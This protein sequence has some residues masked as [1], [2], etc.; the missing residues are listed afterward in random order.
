MGK[1]PVRKMTKTSMIAGLEGSI[2]IS[3]QTVDAKSKKM[4]GVHICNVECATIAGAGCVEWIIETYSIN[5]NLVAAGFA[6]WWTIFV[7]KR[8][9][10]ENAIVGLEY[11]FI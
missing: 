11:L 3:V 9:V 7:L 8:K 10:M 6:K 4:A 1:H 5:Y 2:Y